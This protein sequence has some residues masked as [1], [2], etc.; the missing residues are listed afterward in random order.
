MQSLKGK[1]LT[2]VQDFS[3]EEI[4]QIFE[5]AKELKKKQKGGK[6]HELLKGKSLAMI[7][8]KFGKEW[9]MI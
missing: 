1:H 8:Q 7:F 3:A 4:W 9:L 5:L 6:S 2:T